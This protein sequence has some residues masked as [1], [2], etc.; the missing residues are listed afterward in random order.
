MSK[1]IWILLLLN[2]YI[3]EQ[4]KNAI[5]YFTYSLLLISIKRIPVQ[6]P[7]VTEKILAFLHP[8]LTIFM[9]E[10]T[11]DDATHASELIN[12]IFAASNKN[13]VLIPIRK[14]MPKHQITF[15]SSRVSFARDH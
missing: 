1:Q 2:K 8:L 15:S 9:N 14:L 11:V 3:P 13:P 4:K 12:D 5:K 7:L 10:T 6:K